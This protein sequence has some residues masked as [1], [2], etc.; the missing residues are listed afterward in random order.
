MLP[1]TLTVAQAA[2][3]SGTL[4]TVLVVFGVA[5]VLVIPSL[6]ALYVLDQRS[7]LDEEGGAPRPTYAG[8]APAN[9]ARSQTVIGTVLGAV[10]IVTLAA[11]GRRRRTRSAR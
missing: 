11:V 8:T 5:A 4:E 10:M 6:I 7:I 2:A 1:K 3:P 9:P